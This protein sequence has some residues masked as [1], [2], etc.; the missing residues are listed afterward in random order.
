MRD[1]T[2]Q[3]VLG[4][5]LGIFAYCLMVLR[6]IRE[7]GEGSF[8]P[9]LAVIGGLILAFVGIAVLIYFIHHISLS[10][11]ASS[12]IAAAA[13]E[14][15][16]A[17]EKL[18]PEALGDDAEEGDSEVKLPE[19]SWIEVGARKTGYIESIDE[20]AILAW[21]RKH[22]S[23]VRMDRGIGEFIVE[24]CPLM[25]IAGPGGADEEMV[26]ALNEI[27][28]IGRQRTVEQDAGFGIRQIVDIAMKALSPGVNDTTT[29]VTCVDHLAAILARLAAR[30]LASPR[31]FD[32]GELRVIARGPSFESLLGE[33]FDQIRQN[34]EGNPAILQRQ[35]E[36]LEVIAGRTA[37]SHR[38]RSL[39]RQ[40][41][42]IVAVAERTINSSHD[43]D[44]VK[45]AAM[46]L[47]QVLD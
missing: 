7:E 20:G 29:A 35:L 1:W 47:S 10:I 13:E 21:A 16:A 38:K 25:S 9:S 44:G 28:V 11:Q 31:R 8:V 26:A 30:R 45:A 18:F 3:V 37:C 17:V 32:E 4:V 2:N 39:R 5:F 23:I 19:S 43:A 27:Y 46:R 33:A 24:G 36:S 12:I 6:T 22:Q 41:E 40:A 15:I 14:T 42:L 34:A